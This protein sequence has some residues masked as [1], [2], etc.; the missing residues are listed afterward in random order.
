MFA[1]CDCVLW[2]VGIVAAAVLALVVYVFQATSLPVDPSAA[3]KGGAAGS[4]TVVKVPADY[5]PHPMLFMLRGVLCCRIRGN[6]R[7]SEPVPKMP[8]LEMS[9]DIVL[10]PKQY[11]RFHKHF[12]PS[13]SL[14]GGEAHGKS[15]KPGSLP[16]FITYPNVAGEVMGIASLAH[17]TN[18]L[19]TIPFPVHIGQRV[20]MYRDLPVDATAGCKFSVVAR[21]PTLTPCDNGLELRIVFDASGPDGVLFSRSTLLALYK[22]AGKRKDKAADAKPATPP[23]VEALRRRDA[24]KASEP[25]ERWDVPSGTGSTYAALSGDFNPIHVSPIAAKVLAGFKGA[26]IHGKWTLGKACAALR[27]DGHLRP[28]KDKGVF[29][30]CSFRS[31]L[32]MPGKAAFGWWETAKDGEVEFAVWGKPRKRRAIAEVMDDVYCHG[33]A[34]FCPIP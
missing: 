20:E 19:P 15:G 31:P 14:K 8:N 4:P 23:D 2:G 28:T 25:K 5:N 12:E 17:P 21:P 29:V 27:R 32:V 24:E 10:D 33:T 18:P 6:F 26:I 11:E 16:L 3:P 34:G 13:D 7:R 22:F 9:R 1:D 30:D